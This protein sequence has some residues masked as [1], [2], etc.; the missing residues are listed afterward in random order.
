MLLTEAD[1]SCTSDASRGAPA[2]GLA[3][4]WCELP[5]ILR[6]L[7]HEKAG[8]R[9]RNISFIRAPL[10]IVGSMSVGLTRSIDSSSYEAWAFALAI[11][12]PHPQAK[13]PAWRCSCHFVRTHF[14]EFR[15]AS[16]GAVI[17]GAWM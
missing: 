11:I 16:E 14:E 1:R 6:M 8:H 7:G 2:T 12:L 13:L 4:A 5:S 17:W 15:G 9:T 10:N 3:L